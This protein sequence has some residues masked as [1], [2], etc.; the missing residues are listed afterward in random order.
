MDCSFLGSFNFND[1]IQCTI[2]SVGLGN[3]MFSLF[4]ILTFIVI[5]AAARLE[6][7]ISLA[8]A[9]VLTY[10]LLVFTNSGSYMLTVI[11]A[12]LTLGIALKML[13]AFIGI[14]RQ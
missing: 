11:F 4:V 9:W 14:F 8:I 6:F 10:C 13:I 1:M 5:A 2:Q 3:D 12:V 7:N